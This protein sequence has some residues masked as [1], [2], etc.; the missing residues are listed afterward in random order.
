MYYIDIRMDKYF[1]IEHIKIR[2][3]S[4]FRRD[5]ITILRTQIGNSDISL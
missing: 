2:S 5:L 1:Y 4:F 3:F